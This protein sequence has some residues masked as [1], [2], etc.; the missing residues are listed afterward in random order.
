VNQQDSLLELLGQANPIPD[1][2]RIYEDVEPARRFRAAVEQ[3]RQQPQ[4]HGAR[5][6]VPLSRQNTAGWLAA[7]LTFAAVVVVG[8]VGLLFT[9][10]EEPIVE[11]RPIVST[12]AAEPDPAPSTT[13]PPDPS[14]TTPLPS[15]SSTT[16]SS[17]T[18]TTTTTTTVVPPPPT[19]F[20]SGA[21]LP[22]PEGVRA[23]GPIMGEGPGICDNDDEILFHTGPPAIMRPSLIYEGGLGPFFCLVGFDVER[24]ITVAVSVDGIKLREFVIEPEW[25]IGGAGA[26]GDSYAFVWRSLQA[27][28][29]GEYEL[30]ATQGALGAATSFEVIAPRSRGITIEPRAVTA[31]TPVEIVLF[32]YEANTEVPLRFYR[33]QAEP[34]FPPNDMLLLDYIGT[35]TVTTDEAG[36]ALLRLET[37]TE[38]PLRGYFVEPTPES[39][40]QPSG[41]VCPFSPDV[42]ELVP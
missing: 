17:S 27:D 16:P 1:P 10:G 18:T 37:G 31:G 2:S 26:I 24:P 20:L 12:T 5:V 28:P 32:G 39:G 11:E 36:W 41:C 38:D 13:V 34:A 4:R 21:A 40:W 35:T 25:D 15:T 19:S 30:V 9:R 33:E 6:M 3:K 23:P 42:F 7:A 8:G 14:T 22:V 29:L